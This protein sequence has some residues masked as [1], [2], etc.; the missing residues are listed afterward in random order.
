[1]NGYYIAL[2]GSD[3]CGKSTQHKLLINALELAYPDREIFSTFEP[4]GSSFG[5]ELRA[6]AIEPKTYSRETRALAIALDRSLNIAESIVPALNRGAIVIADRCFV[7][8]LVYQGSGEDLSEDLVM[9]TAQLA[10][11]EVIPDLVLWIDV[12]PRVA[13]ERLQAAGK[14]AD[15][16]EAKGLD[17]Q[18][19]IYNGYLTFY[20][21]DSDLLT[22]IDGSRSPAE[23]H[24]QIMSIVEN[25][26]DPVAADFLPKAVDTGA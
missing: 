22:R 11:G 2:E 23:V 13:T 19:K 16:F 25:L 1:M 18:R 3:G 17:F 20:S 26:I 12:L 10:V 15:Y 9:A 6:I 7:S 8:S 4:G 21:Q 24:E 5:T 14:P